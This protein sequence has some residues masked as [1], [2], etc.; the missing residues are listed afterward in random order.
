MIINGDMRISQRGGT[1]ATTGSLVQF[2][3]IDR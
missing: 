1:T 3:V 2:M